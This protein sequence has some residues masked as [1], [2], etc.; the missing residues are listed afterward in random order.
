[1]CAAHRHFTLPKRKRN[2]RKIH[3]K[4]VAAIRLVLCPVS[5]RTATHVRMRGDTCGKRLQ[6]PHWVKNNQHERE[7]TRNRRYA[8]SSCRCTKGVDAD[9]VFVSC[10]VN[11]KRHILSHNREYSQNSL[12]VKYADDAFAKNSL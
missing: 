10:S 2:S 7:R 4:L 3:C 6:F 1:M 9:G 12:F 8:A 5:R 11:R